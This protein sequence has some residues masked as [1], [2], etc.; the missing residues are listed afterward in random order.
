MGHEKVASLIEPFVSAGPLANYLAFF[1]CFNRGL[2]FEAH[3]VL[4]IIWLPERGQPRERFYKGL[5]Q[6]A[7][8]FVHFRKNRASP[9]A[10]LLRLARNNLEQY[11][12]RYQGL[13]VADL[14]SSI[15]GLLAQLS[16]ANVPVAS[17]IAP[18]LRLEPVPPCDGDARA[19]ILALTPP[20]ARRRFVREVGRTNNSNPKS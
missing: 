9:G 14:V 2:F 15:D 12:P 8:A 4:E 6:F 13:E 19:K 1:D 16:T 3:E 5:I 20:L 18:E 17:L 11:L 10:A 7:G